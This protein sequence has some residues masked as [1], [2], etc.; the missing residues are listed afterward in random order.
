MVSLLY[1]QILLICIY[2]INYCQKYYYT[3]R[4]DIIYIQIIRF[5]LNIPLM[6]IYYIEPDQYMVKMNL[7]NMENIIIIHISYYNILLSIISKFELLLNL[8][9]ILV[10][11]IYKRIS[12]FY[13]S[14]NLVNKLY[15]IS[16]QLYSNITLVDIFYNNMSLLN[17][18]N[19]LEG[20]KHMQNLI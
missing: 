10:N 20:K 3:F 17:L 2:N 15:R 9:R 19:Y 16:H 5:L 18:N 1:L 14:N 7:F 13:L 8:N 12:R 6:Y 11:N 4:Q